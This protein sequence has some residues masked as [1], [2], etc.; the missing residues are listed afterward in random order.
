MVSPSCPSS[1]H[2]VGFSPFS[3][4]LPLQ[5]NP[6]HDFLSAWNGFGYFLI[7]LTPICPSNLSPSGTFFRKIV[8]LKVFLYK[9]Q[10]LF[11]TKQKKNVLKR[12]L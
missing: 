10:K 7:Q 6:H 1:S 12:Y 9:Q 5:Y 2:T 11:W 8:S 3:E 4:H